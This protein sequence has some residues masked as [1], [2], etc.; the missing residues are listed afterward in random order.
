MEG[1]RGLLIRLTVSA[2]VVAL[3]WRQLAAGEVL[4]LLAS[5]PWW[6]FAVPTALML[7]NAWL[8]A[9]RTKL[10]LRAAGVSVPLWPLYGALLRAVFVGL[11]LPTGGGELAKVAMVGRLTGRPDAALAALAAARLLEL[12]PWS[13][14]LLFGLASGIIGHDPLLVVTA[15]IASSAF[16]GA[17]L[18]A[19]VGARLGPALARRL[20]G[21][22]GLF[23][24]RSA[25]ALLA[26]GQQP[27]LVAAA[28]ALAVP[29]ALLNG[30]AIWTALHGH[31]I[32]LRYIEVLAIFP[33]ADVLTSLPITISGVG[34]REGVFVHVLAPFGVGE[35][36][37]V[38]AGL[39]RWAGELG[40][41][42]VGGLWL[43]VH[44]GREQSV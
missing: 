27:A 7:T 9:L 15:T 32:A 20:P 24:E 12:I 5:A 17:V 42:A 33:A 11:V 44:R 41:A 3:V 25:Q 36:A 1:R 30:L 6:A 4:G 37:A 26:V 21:R 2:A 23:A 34:V 10:L 38:A 40:R 28:L 13:A 31:G 43:V 19:A 16:L 29:F 35:A 14:L 18:I 22:L 39:T 8:H